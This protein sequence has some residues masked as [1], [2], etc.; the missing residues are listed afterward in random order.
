MNL[1]DAIIAATSLKT[2]IQLVTL[3]TKHFSAIKELK[4]FKLE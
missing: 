1:I 3:N 4:I 2:K